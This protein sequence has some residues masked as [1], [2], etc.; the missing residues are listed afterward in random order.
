MRLAGILEKYEALRVDA[1]MMS[2]LHL[3]YKISL[4]IYVLRCSF[5]L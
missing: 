1:I 5:E 4:K 2:N 3:K